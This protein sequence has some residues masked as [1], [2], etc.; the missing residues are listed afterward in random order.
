VLFRETHH[1]SGAAVKMA[2]DRGIALSSLSVADLQSIHPLFEED[3][4][5]VGRALSSVGEHRGPLAVSW[6]SFAWSFG[7]Q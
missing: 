4:V 3:V 7:T 2:E 6:R 1:V 5:K